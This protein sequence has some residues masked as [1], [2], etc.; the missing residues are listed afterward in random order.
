MEVYIGMIFLFAGNFAPT[1]FMLCEGQL[2]PIAQYT[3]LFSILGTNY[4]GNGQSTFGLPDL[5]GRVPVG[6]GQG[7]Q[8]SPYYLGQEGGSETATIL[9]AN[10]PPHTHALMGNTGVAG[11]EYP[12]PNHVIGPSMTDKMYSE[13]A[14]NTT[15]SPGAIGMS[16]SGLPV[17]TVPPYQAINYIIAVQ[18]LYP[19]RN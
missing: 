19:P 17:P 2:L 12:G 5:R 9:Q 16:G 7:P 10:M 18:G 11:K 1:G 13:A 4:G 15:M 8:L 6:V 14:P 3:A